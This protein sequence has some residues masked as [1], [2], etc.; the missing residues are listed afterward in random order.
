[1]LMP[2]KI[3][4]V[5]VVYNPEKDRLIN[6]IKAFVESVD[7]IIIWQNSAENFESLK[8]WE[9]KIIFM[10]NCKNQY[11]A[12]PLNCVLK[13]C[14]SNGYDYL[15]TMDQDSI[16]HDCSSFITKVKEM[17]ENDVAIYAPNVNEQFKSD[18]ESL[19][20]ES[21]IT[22]G[23]L[24]NVDIACKLGGFREDYQIYW[25]DG[26]FCFWARKNGYTIK[27]L[28]QFHLSQ[29]FGEQSKTILG[30]SASNYSP[31][32]YYF[33]FRNMLW[34]KREYHENP[35]LKCV[36]YTSLYNIRGIVLGE[37]KKV[38]KLYMIGKAWWDGLFHP[39]VKR[40]CC[41]LK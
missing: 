20:V 38:R 14:K 35:S 37:N 9:N 41:P 5:V 32:V 33:L 15:L 4:A 27:V 28:P 11:I 16:W 13:W 6:N 26:E 21:V 22:S 31:I 36:L 25:V 8:K 2:N 23:S 10:G 19:I 29:R 12:H 39:I 34:M 30:Y 18:K 3:A 1:M 7:V 40:T 17:Y 24:C